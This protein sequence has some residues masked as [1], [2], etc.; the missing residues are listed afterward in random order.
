VY[1]IAMDCFRF[2]LYGL[3][4]DV[5]DVKLT[6]EFVILGNTSSVLKL[7]FAELFEFRYHEFLT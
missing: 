6:F 7:C 2:L 4:A 1:V 3:S 5:D